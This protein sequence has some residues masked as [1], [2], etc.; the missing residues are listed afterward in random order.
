MKKHLDGSCDL[1]LAQ[2]LLSSYIQVHDP[3]NYEGWYN[4]GLVCKA[5]GRLD[6]AKKHLQYAASLAA[7]SPV[8]SF[9]S[10]PRVF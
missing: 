1:I 5:Q 6:E 8:K 2:S 9:K 4:L 10:L 3:S 7:I